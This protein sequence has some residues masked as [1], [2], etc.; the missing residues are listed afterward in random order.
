MLILINTTGNNKE[1]N[2]VN[3]HLI[4]FVHCIL[5][6]GLQHLQLGLQ[7]LQITNQLM[8]HVTYLSSDFYAHQY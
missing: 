2:I 7:Q 3:L 4:I 1:D 6:D 8:L 5:I